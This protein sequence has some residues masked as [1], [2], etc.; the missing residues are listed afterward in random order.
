MPYCFY[1]FLLI[2]GLF[3]CSS[4][5]QED[6]KLFYYTSP[7]EIDLEEKSSENTNIY[8]SGNEIN[9]S[10]SIASS[11]LP[12]SVIVSPEVSSSDF[13]DDNYSDDYIPSKLY[14]RSE[15]ILYRYGHVISYNNTIRLP[16]WVYWELTD[17]RVNGNVKRMRNYSPDLNIKNGPIADNSDYRST[18]YEK[19]HM[20]PA[21]DNK[22]S[23]K[24]M[25]DSFLLSNVCPQ[26]HELN[27][28]D[29]RI[30]EEKCRTWAKRYK[31]LYIVCGPII[32]KSASYEKIGE[33]QIVV[34]DYYYKVILRPLGKDSY[35]GVGF[36]FKNDQTSQK[37]RDYVV[38]ID[39]VEKYTGLD[40]FPSLPDDVEKY[41]ESHV[42][43]NAWHKL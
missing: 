14:D 29:W 11:E 2:F 18:R 39:E 17:S 13:S 30:L 26:T 23:R 8:S 40:F 3:S 22:Y 42:D 16:N 32:D 15:E 37:I 1:L 19:G 20:C 24:A 38:S 34:P 28:G 27:D 7:D 4:S 31:L 41:V 10:N 21:G 25:E 5:R 43:L 6:E 36:I 12:S 33:N 9:P 35:Q